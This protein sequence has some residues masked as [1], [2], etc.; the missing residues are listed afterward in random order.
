[1]RIAVPTDGTRGKNETVAEHFGMCRYFSIFDENENFLETIENTSQHM[2]GKGLPP[3]LLKENNVDVLVCRGLGPNAIR[4]C[5]TLGIN[6]H[7]AQARKAHEMVALW[8]EKAAR[9]ASIADGCQ[10][11]KH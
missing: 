1:M 9:E 10:D 2:G 11:H 7:L 3:E 5:G 6:V 4:L 8:R